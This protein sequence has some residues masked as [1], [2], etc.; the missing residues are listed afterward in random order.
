MIHV[1]SCGHDS[2]HPNPCDI[3]HKNGLP[4]YLLL[5]I[6]TGAWAF[7]N[8]R[9]IFT[10]PN[11]VI[12]FDKNTYIHY[13]CNDPDYN[14]DWIHFFIDSGSDDDLISRLKIP[15]NQPLYPPDVQRL[16]RFV[17]LMSREFRFPAD[18]SGQ[19]LDSLMKGLLLSLAE[20]L[21]KGEQFRSGHR[22]YSAFLRLRTA[23]YNSPSMQWSAEKMAGSL[24]LSV[25][26]FQ[27]LYKQFFA[28]SAQSDIIRARLELAK[29]YLTHS[30]MTICSVASFCGYDSEVHFMRQFKKFEGM[31][32]SA[33]RKKMCREAF[34]PEN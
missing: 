5:I 8:G 23:L 10:E 26:Y 11:M 6:K 19:I 1:T 12:L 21:G 14:D 28:A 30:N 32:P 15:L 20:D 24:D 29:Y 16:S 33:F 9:R 4:D 17:Q 25:S 2:R 18:Y 27:H 34:S 31:T 3:E 22:H 7:I 13:G